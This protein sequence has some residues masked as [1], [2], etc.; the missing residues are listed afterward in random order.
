MNGSIQDCVVLEKGETCKIN[1]REQSLRT[2]PHKYEVIFDKNTKA[3]QWRKANCSNG[4][5]T[6]FAIGKKLNPQSEPSYLS[7]M[8]VR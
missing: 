4:I 1:S 7:K 8:Q 3:I 6:P 2:N 5:R